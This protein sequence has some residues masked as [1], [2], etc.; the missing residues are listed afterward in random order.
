MKSNNRRK[1]RIM[2]KKN[3]PENEHKKIDELNSLYDEWEKGFTSPQKIFMRYGFYPHYFSM[4]PRILFVAAEATGEDRFDYIDA[5]YNCYKNEK[6]I[7]DE[8]N[9]PIH[10]NS[11]TFHR[12]ILQIAYSILNKTNTNIPSASEIGDLIGERNGISF[13]F[14]N[15]SNI[16]NQKTVRLDRE[17][18]TASVNKWS[19]YFLKEMEI[20]DPQI[21]IIGNIISNKLDNRF[22]YDQLKMKPISP[23]G[24]ICIHKG[25]LNGHDVIG[26]ETYHFSALKHNKDIGIKDD[27]SF[28]NPIFDYINNR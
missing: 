11:Y 4:N 1:K 13:A 5:L 23:A 17:L 2:N 3:Y 24:D 6:Y 9:K 8:N 12:R 27:E 21:V 26:I 19:E 15:I 18:V 14:K 16:L 10:V 22:F 25:T 7:G 28:I 20:L